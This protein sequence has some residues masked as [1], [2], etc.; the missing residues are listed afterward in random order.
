MPGGMINI[1]ATE[2]YNGKNI[3]RIPHPGERE[4]NQIIRDSIAFSDIKL[5]HREMFQYRIILTYFHF[6]LFHIRL[7][8]SDLECQHLNLLAGLHG[9][10]QIS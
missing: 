8:L 2:K 4:V 7:Q 6:Q 3:E 1:Y 9:L 10:M 5:I